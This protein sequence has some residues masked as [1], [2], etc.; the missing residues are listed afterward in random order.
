MTAAPITKLMA[1]LPS[2]L[3]RPATHGLAI[4]FGM[5]TSFRSST[6]GVRPPSIRPFGAALFGSYQTTAA[7]ARSRRAHRHRRRPP[8]PRRERAADV[9]V[10]DRRRLGGRLQLLYSVEFNRN[11]RRLAPASCGGSRAA[12]SRG[13]RDRPRFRRDVSR[14]R[15]PQH[16]WGFHLRGERPI[17][18]RR[19]RCSPACRRRPPA[20]SWVGPDEARA[21]LARQLP[22]N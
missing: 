7:D 8:L 6:L 15:I 22:R 10:V 20:T 3:E 12:T 17:S 5:G 18:C 21:L 19:R 4:C 11:R 1:H 14:A 2:L 13:G 16:R 9:I